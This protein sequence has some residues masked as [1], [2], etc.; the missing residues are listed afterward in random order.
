MKTIQTSPAIRLADLDEA[1]VG[2][3]AGLL[4]LD[5]KPGDTIALHGDLGAGKTTL[6]RALIRA[7][8]GEAEL[9]VVSPTFSLVQSYDGKRGRID[10]YDLYRLKEPGEAEEIGLSDDGGD[11]IRIIEWPERVGA[12]GAGNRLDIHIHDKL[13]PSTRTLDLAPTGTFTARLERLLAARAFIAHADC[14][15]AD[16]VYL[17]GDAST[18]R[19]ARLVRADGSSAILMD[20]PRQPDGP[21]VRDGM[22]YSRIAHLAE[23]VRPF[24]AIDRA[25]RGAGLSA[26]AILAED[27]DG[28]FLLL[29]DLGDR[30]YGRETDGGA[31][32]AE[33]WTA[34]LDML[35]A[36][37]KASLPMTMPASPH[38][39][40]A[41]THT[42]APLDATIL[43]IEVALLPDWH[44]PELMGTA[45]PAD[46][47]FEYEA[48][49]RPVI[50][51]LLAAPTGWIL[52]DVHSPNLLWL[53]ERQSIARVG[54]ID[55]QDAI[56]GPW[57][58]D[59][60]SLLQD[61][62]VDVPEDLEIELLARYCRRMSALPGFDEALFRTTYA[63]YGAL[64]ATRLLGLFVR[65][66]RRD[67][68]PDYLAHIPR[69]WR[70]LERNLRHPALQ[71]LENWFAHHFPPDLRNR[72][73][74][75]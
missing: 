66:L 32:Q 4:A 41:G 52:R 31:H 14:S 38:A 12:P 53:P 65:L 16:I 6:A 59:V 17:Q 25:L 75:P 64:R 22:P 56:A 58:H 20:A 2:R 30:V 61:A 62:R 72:A 69:N 18:R 36:F 11:V 27:L 74:T 21:V 43:G 33:L 46:V 67:G 19:Y 49:W 50:D 44:W 5:L 42:L 13:R 37:R 60:M 51:L 26:P 68:K 3:F 15:D 1:A 9:E 63:A 55:F 54:I 35:V 10:H 73:I 48:L 34:A 57:A 70:Y 8:T 24:V 39:P 29:E 45:M 28:G 71:P 47:R 23:D 40:A 7:Y